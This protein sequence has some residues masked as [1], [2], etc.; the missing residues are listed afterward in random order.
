MIALPRT[1]LVALA[2][3]LAATA[4]VAQETTPI[5]PGTVRAGVLSFDGKA[6]AGDFTG[7]TSTVTGI[8]HAA[9]A[10]ASVTGVVEAPVQTLVTGN[11]RRDKD[12][13]KSMESDNF[14]TIRFELE[15]V[16]SIQPGP[17]S[18]VAQLRGQMIVHGVTHPVLLPAS[19][20][21]TAEGVQVKTSFPLNLKD[22]RIGGL[23]KMFGMF[24]MH[25]DI[26]V[27]VD[28]QFQYQ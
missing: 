27:H 28:V 15:G 9:V 23:S 13:N 7:T 2:V 24:K 16:D 8:L 22:Y 14:P 1:I 20:H 11:S 26:V 5:R 25:P 4:V 18:T 19:L 10:L 21:F 3:T 17:D 12:L 6:T